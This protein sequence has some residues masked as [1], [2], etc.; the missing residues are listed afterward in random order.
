[1]RSG[2]FIFCLALLVAPAVAF[3]GGAVTRSIRAGSKFR[4]LR[5][6][7]G[8]SLFLLLKSYAGARPREYLFDNNFDLTPCFDTDL[9]LKDQP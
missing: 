6:V 1:M 8:V 3:F 9:L 4:Y 2:F 7:C 5:Y